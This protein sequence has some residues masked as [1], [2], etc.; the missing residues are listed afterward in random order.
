MDLTTRRRFERANTDARGFTLVATLLV[1]VILGVLAAMVFSR[2]SHSTTAGP[3][4]ST[5]PGPTSTL[6]SSVGAGTDLAVRTTCE[7][8]F[9]IVTVALNAYRA[10]NRASPSPGRAWATSST[11]GGPFLKSW[12][13]QPRF[14]SITWNGTVLGVVPATGD[15]SLASA[16]T[17]SPRTGCYA[18]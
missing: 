5:T 2:Q 6:P 13:G 8:D 9:Q 12:P 7:A 14:F 15:S 10:L 17:S 4:A 18:A 11:N 1:V 3:G 16:G